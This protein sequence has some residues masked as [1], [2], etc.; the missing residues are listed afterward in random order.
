MRMR[1][2]IVLLLLYVNPAIADPS[3]FAHLDGNPELRSAS[4]LILDAT[5]NTVY[6]KDTERVR[7]IASITKLMT[8][9]V[10]LDSALDLE[11]AVTITK[12]DRDNLRGTGSRLAIGSTLSRRELVLLAVM[13][14]ENR[15]ASA[16]AR[17]YPGGTEA[18]VRAMNEKAGALG[19]THSRFS[20]ATGL[21]TENLSTARDLALM[22][23]AASDY[24][25]ITQAST[26][27]AMEVYPAPERGPLTYRNTNRLLNK[28]DWQIGLSKTGFIREAGRCL[29]MRARIGGEDFSIV[30][31][32]SFGKLTPFGDSNRLR[33]W[34]LAQN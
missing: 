4:A 29:V 27:E 11:Q 24:P 23:K 34:L 8:A 19:M 20:D 9:M 5:G 22:I 13:A 14:S 1:A 16:L 10:I 30:L 26:T 33:R 6:G 32:N 15:A 21:H 31:L 2:A 25:L 17:T 3:R 28:P 7:S 12:D 18:F